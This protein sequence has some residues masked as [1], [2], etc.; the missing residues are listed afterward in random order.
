MILADI[1]RKATL[2]YPKTTLNVIRDSADNRLLE[3]AEESDADFLITGNTNDFII[4]NY[5][6]TRIVGPKE[7][8]ENHS[9]Y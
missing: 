3:L 7:Y 4:A 5:K 8:Y 6:K 2:F 9:P 1:E